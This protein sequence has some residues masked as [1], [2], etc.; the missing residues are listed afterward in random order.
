MYYLPYAT[1]ARVL[2]HYAVAQKSG[3]I[4]NSTLLA[5]GHL[6]RIR[7][8]DSSALCVLM[9]IKVGITIV[10]AVTIALE[11]AFRAIVVRGFTVD[12]T[13]AATNANMTAISNTGEMRQSM[14]PSLMGIAGPGICTT[15]VMSGQTL[16]ADS[17]PFCI[18][19]VPGLMATNSGAAAVILPVGF[20]SPMITLYEWTALG[21]HPVVLAQ[22][23]GVVV[24]NHLAG[25]ASGT[26]ILYVQWEWAEVMAV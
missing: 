19:P 20:A 21:Q 3:S 1:P 17:D 24:Q 5:A 23:E 11:Q 6:A 8:T 9:R 12:F 7:W 22:N 18:S 14:N 4:V 15:V 16:T 10:G 13:T 2:G 26:F 25:A